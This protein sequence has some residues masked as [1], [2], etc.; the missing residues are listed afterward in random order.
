M[1]S[2][3]TTGRSP[4]PN[5]KR[6]RPAIFSKIR[7]FPISIRH[8]AEC[9]NSI[10]RRPI[11]KEAPDPADTRIGILAAHELRRLVET[12]PLEACKVLSKAE[13]FFQQKVYQVHDYSRDADGTYGNT[14]LDAGTSY[15]FTNSDGTLIVH[16]S[17][18]GPIRFSEDE[19]WFEH[20]TLPASVLDT[21]RNEAAGARLSDYIT[22]DGFD[23]DLLAPDGIEEV[24][25]MDMLNPGGSIPTKGLIPLHKDIHTILRYPIQAIPFPN[26]A[27]EIRMRAVSVIGKQV[28]SPEGEET[29]GNDE[30]P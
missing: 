30:T 27:H 18:P 3:A 13:K 5:E 14:T 21:I 12:H 20:R 26:F 17:P 11:N 23:I 7:T 2:P 15:L 25:T 16:V 19:A 22:V 24:D 29:D 8:H 10:G 6:R 1:P 4:R 28:H 9:R